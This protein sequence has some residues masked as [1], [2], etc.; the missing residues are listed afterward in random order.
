MPISRIRWGEV[1]VVVTGSDQRR[2]SAPSFARPPHEITLSPRQN[3]PGAAV[4]VDVLTQLEDRTT[5]YERA[6][7]GHGL[8]PV[9]IAVIGAGYWGPNLVRNT[10]QST[11][12]RLRAV[13]DVDLARAH[14][15]AGNYSGVKVTEDLQA[16]LADPSVEAIAVATPAGTHRD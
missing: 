12:T 14:A 11:A 5:Q 1:G 7:T 3:R 16:V 10:L 6:A 2:P 15:V 13:C 4:Y 9:G 8:E